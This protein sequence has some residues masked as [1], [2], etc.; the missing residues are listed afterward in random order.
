MSPRAN[1][2]RVTPAAGASSPGGPAPEA[3]A[4]SQAG[5]AALEPLAQAWRELESAASSPTQ[6]FIWSQSCAESFH[7]A[8]A[9]QVVVVRDRGRTTA[10]APLVRTRGP[11]PRLEALGVRELF[12]PMDFLYA[13]AAALA[14]LSDRLARQPLPLRLQRVPDGSPMVAALT[15]AFQGRG[16]IHS[17]PIS[18]C[19]F[20]DL[21]ASWAEPEKHFNSGRRSDFRRARRHAE[22]QGAVTFEVLSPAPGEVGAL[23]DE[24]LSVEALSWKGTQGTALVRDPARARFFHRYASAA[25]AQR[26]LRLVFM[27]I[28]GRAVGMQIAV[29]CQGRFWLLKIG[30][31]EGVAKCSPG[32]L[33]ML[34]SVQYAAARGLTSY[35]FLGGAAP[36]TATWTKTLRQCTVVRAYPFSAAGMAALAWDTGRWAYQRVKRRMENGQDEQDKPEGQDREETAG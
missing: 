31:D 8:R 9:P 23:V 10:I 4:P 30:Y 7:D 21:D 27:R 6:Q 14:A 19:P 26:I 15:R 29:E 24:A 25:A 1:A 2:D 35:E 5:G 11:L 36:W 18:P 33:L 12:E 28:A 17:A 13:D 20:I 22:Q 34:H 3:A 32:N 16:V